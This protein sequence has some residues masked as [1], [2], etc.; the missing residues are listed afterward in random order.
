MIK[1]F[2][3]SSP[4]WLLATIRNGGALVARLKPPLIPRY[5]TSSSR[6]RVSSPPRQRV[7]P[8]RLSIHPSV[9]PSVRSFARSVDPCERS[10]LEGCQSR[11]TVREP[12]AVR[13][14]DGTSLLE[15]TVGRLL[16][17]TATADAEQNAL[18][19][20]ACPRDPRSKTSRARV[21]IRGILFAC[22][23]RAAT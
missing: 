6:V 10:L 14:L 9:R 17:S 22:R 18:Q 7:S 12:L 3:A 5:L 11:V 20:R 16:T 1:R 15:T 8:C 13:G 21:I 19:E 2:R 23:G 4:T